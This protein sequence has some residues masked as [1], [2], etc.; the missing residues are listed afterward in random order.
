MEVSFEENVALRGFHVYGKEV[1]KSPN[2]GQKLSTEKEKDL[3]VLKIDPY[4]VAGKLKTKD[5]LIP[6]VVGHI[7]REI[8]CF[9]SFFMDYGERMEGVVLSP[10]FNA[11]P[12]PRGGL[13]IILKRRFTIAEEKSKYLH[14]LKELVKDDYESV[15]D[16][17]RSNNGENRLNDMEQHSEEKQ[18][19]HG[20]DLVIFIDDESDN[21]NCNCI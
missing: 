17:R 9:V 12:I 5:K 4:Y 14:H 3:L 19:E 1:W 20:M 10:E 6:M 18:Q 11:S 13:E 7:P 2:T 15:T 8:S 21:C 16:L